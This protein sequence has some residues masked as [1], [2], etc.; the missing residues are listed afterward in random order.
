SVDN[1]KLV[2]LTIAIPDAVEVLVRVKAAGLNHS[3][4]KNVLGRFP[5]TTLPRVPGRDYAGIVEQGPQELL[6]KAVWGTGKGP[7]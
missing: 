7:G 4:L 6:G 1:L 2:D 3:D 5:Y